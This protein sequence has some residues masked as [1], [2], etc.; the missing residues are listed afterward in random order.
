MWFSGE[1]KREQERD[2]VDSKQR[3]QLRNEGGERQKVQMKERVQ[4]NSTWA[5]GR[6]K[7][8]VPSSPSRL[9]FAMFIT[10]IRKNLKPALLF[11]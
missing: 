5:S 10:K 9:H 8:E 11:V 2:M 4:L 3:S 7:I 6:V 1:Q